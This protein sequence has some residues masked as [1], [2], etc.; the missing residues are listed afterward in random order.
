M[1]YRLTEDLSDLICALATATTVVKWF[2]YSSTA[3]RYGLE[4]F[5]DRPRSKITVLPYRP[6]SFRFGW[7]WVRMIQNGLWLSVLSVEN[8][9]K[10]ICS[11]P[12]VSNRT[13]EMKTDCY[14][15]SR[16]PD[17][18]SMTTGSGARWAV[19]AVF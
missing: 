13:P 15:Y 17:K 9:I 16:Q 18:E 4:T 12:G 7:G 6:S 1:G 11:V 5:Y 8:L 19:N 10:K 14:S 2:E 3:L